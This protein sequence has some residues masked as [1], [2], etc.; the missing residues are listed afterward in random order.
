ME[1]NY[2]CYRRFTFPG[3]IKYV[4]QKRESIKKMEEWEESIQRRRERKAQLNKSSN[5]VSN[6]IDPAGSKK[7]M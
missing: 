6:I 3:G 2:D 5:N 4:K 7:S 1:Q